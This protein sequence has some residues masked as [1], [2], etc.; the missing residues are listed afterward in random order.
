MFS[1]LATKVQETENEIP[2]VPACP[3]RLEARPWNVSGA[4]G[5]RNGAA[6]PVA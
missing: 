5:A 1:T 4:L 3:D 6:R 2:R